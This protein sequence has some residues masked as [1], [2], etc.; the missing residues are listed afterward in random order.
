M[1]L[2]RAWICRNWPV[3]ESH[4]Q[5]VADDLKEGWSVSGPDAAQHDQGRCD[6]FG[7]R[8]HVSPNGN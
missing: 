3:H 1:R 2:S 6:N 8:L 5:G 4:H 7:W